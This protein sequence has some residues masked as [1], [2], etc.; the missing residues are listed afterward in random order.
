MI[1]SLTIN[2]VIKFL[3][4]PDS[5]RRLDFHLLVSYSAGND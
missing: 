5:I 4:G 3:N 1:L 2:M